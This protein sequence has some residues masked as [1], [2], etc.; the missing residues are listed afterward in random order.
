MKLDRIQFGG[1]GWKRMFNGKDVNGNVPSNIALINL[2]SRYF[3]I[4]SE[5][6]DKWKI[7]SI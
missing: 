7:F 1:F 3:T 6:I 5:C 2:I 4:Y